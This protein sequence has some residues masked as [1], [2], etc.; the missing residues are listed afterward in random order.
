MSI[1]GR[2]SVANMRKIMIYNTDVD[3]VIDNVH[4]KFGQILSIPSQDIDQKLNSDINQ[5]PLL[6]CKFA[7]NDDLQSQHRSC[8]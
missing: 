6:C 7:N 1:K 3:L 8:Q 5:G 2:N 4:T